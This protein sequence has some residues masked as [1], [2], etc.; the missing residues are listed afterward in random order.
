MN[1]AALWASLLALLPSKI[2]QVIRRTPSPF[3]VPPA[4]ELTPLPLLFVAPMIPATWVPWPEPADQLRRLPFT[5]FAAGLP[6]SL[7]FTKLS[8]KAKQPTKLKP[9]LS[10]MY[11]LPSSSTPI[12]PSI[13]AWFFHRASTRS[14]CTLFTAQSNT[15]TTTLGSPAVSL[16]ASFTPTSAPSTALSVI[17]PSLTRFH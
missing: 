2:W 7:L 6:S 17:V 8:F 16:H 11:P 10:S 1:A 15:A 5:A 13:S 4:I 12:W 3:P 14:S 9:Y